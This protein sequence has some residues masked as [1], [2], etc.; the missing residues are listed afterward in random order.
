MEEKEY[1]QIQAK[2]IDL[3]ELDEPIPT[4]RDPTRRISI[5]RNFFQ[6]GI[7]LLLAGELEKS[8]DFLARAKDIYSTCLDFGDCQDLIQS[9]L[10]D[11]FSGT[12]EPVVKLRKSKDLELA[13]LK[14]E[15][16]TYRM[17]MSY[18]CG[19]I[20][21]RF[22]K[23]HLRVFRRESFQ[24]SRHF[25]AK[26]DDKYAYESIAD[27]LLE[28]A[29]LFL[30]KQSDRAAVTV[31][32]QVQLLY[33][34]ALE[35]I[36]RMLARENPDWSKFIELTDVQ[37]RKQAP[38]EAEEYI[39][40]RSQLRGN[41]P[42]NR[43]QGELILMLAEMV[44]EYNRE[45]CEKIRLKFESFFDEV[46]C[47]FKSRQDVGVGLLEMLEWV[48]IKKRFH[49][50]LYQKSPPAEEILRTCMLSTSAPRRI[51]G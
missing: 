48:V 5:A 33:Q 16:E 15:K 30:I 25:R 10:I 8:Q 29:R 46:L 21:D 3:D 47:S 36:P 42:Y 20:F 44:N 23:C 40:K 49:Y 17:V 31:V 39:K 9:Y 41:I 38:G 50:M 1:W 27:R 13:L 22:R 24:A 18:S 32:K 6:N 51:E 35:K 28:I 43:R 34:A 19:E 2:M 14:L 37:V 4:S 26:L 11:W 7:T 12:G 45:K